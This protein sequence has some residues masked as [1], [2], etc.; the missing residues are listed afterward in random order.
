MRLIH[1]LELNWNCRL[2]Q[3]FK[4]FVTDSRLPWSNG[5]EF[6]FRNY[7]LILKSTK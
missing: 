3:E 2:F 4:N 7:Y 1:L 5:R 6:T